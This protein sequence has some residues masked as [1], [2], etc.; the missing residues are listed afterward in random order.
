M[1]SARAD[2]FA[3]VLFFVND[4]VA[5]FFAAEEKVTKALSSAPDH[6]R[7]HAQLGY[8]DTYTK[9]ATEGIAECEHALA[10]DQNVAQAHSGIGWGKIFLGRAEETEARIAAAL[11]VAQGKGDCVGEVARLGGRQLVDG[12]G[13]RPDNSDFRTEQELLCTDVD[14]N[15]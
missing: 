15:L 7:G 10:L 12:I 11:R 1:E 8:I 4:P 13:H 5:A 14:S 9:R 3:G 2:F 6:A